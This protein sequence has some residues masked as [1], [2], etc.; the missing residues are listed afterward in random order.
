MKYAAAYGWVKTPAATLSPPRFEVAGCGALS[1]PR[2]NLGLPDTAARRR[3]RRSDGSLA[4]GLQ[5]QCGSPAQSSTMRNLKG[6]DVSARCRR[7]R[8]ENRECYQV[9]HRQCRRDGG[10][11]ALD[12][13]HGGRGG[14]VLEHNA[15]LGE[16]FVE[17]L[18]CRQ[19]RLFG[20]EHCDILS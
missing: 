6:D 20:V 16:A 14:A 3:A 19:K 13:F 9:M 15:Q 8:L 1:V 12:C 11:A 17:F 18:E 4:T 10:S 2:K 5:K 7:K